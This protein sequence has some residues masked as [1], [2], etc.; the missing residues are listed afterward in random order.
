MITDTQGLKT[1]IMGIEAQGHKVHEAPAS[2]DEDTDRVFYVYTVDNCGKKMRNTIA[3]LDPE[4]PSKQNGDYR[5]WSLGEY[6]TP[7]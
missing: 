7:A 1:H 6:T 2:S 5:I 3:Y 4:I